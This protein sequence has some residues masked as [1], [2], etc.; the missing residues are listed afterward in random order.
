M[1]LACLALASNALS[2]PLPARRT[3]AA[4]RATPTRRVR[5]ARVR[6]ELPPSAS[7]G[8]ANGG[9]LVHPRLLREGPGVRFLPGRPLHHGTDELVGL[10]ERVGRVMQR[11]H[12]VPITVGDLSAATGGRVVRH[13]S[14]QSGRDADVAFFMRALRDGAPVGPAVPPNDYV[15]FDALGVSVDRRY[16][17][18]T[19]RNWALVEAFLTDPQVIVER[20]FVARAQRAALLRYARTRTRADVYARAQWALHQPA[21]AAVHDNHFHVR[22]ACP[23]GDAECREGVR[24]PP[25]RAR[26]RG[27]VA[28]RTPPRRAGATR[29]APHTPPRAANTPARAAVPPTPA[30]VPRRR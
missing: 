12:H 23:R 7:V 24:Q 29:S 17:F 15:S 8:W 16:T 13:H 22:I 28:L 4:Q 25:P 3:P 11:R 18:D 6:R 27:Q 2:D 30:R 20:L 14:H 19:P 1:L 5:R 9:S 21:H 26:R 10:L